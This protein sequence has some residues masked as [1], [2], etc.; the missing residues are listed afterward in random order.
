MTPRKRRWLIASIAIIAIAWIAKEVLWDSFTTLRDN[1]KTVFVKV[2]PHGISAVFDLKNGQTLYLP[3]DYNVV[4]KA[5]SQVYVGSHRNYW[6]RVFKNGQ[7]KDDIRGQWRF[8]IATG[9]YRLEVRERGTDQLISTVYI[10]AYFTK[11]EPDM[12]DIPS[13]QTAGGFIYPKQKTLSNID[14]VFNLYGGVCLKKSE[15]ILRRIPMNKTETMRTRQGKLFFWGFGFALPRLIS[16][17]Q[18]GSG[19]E[20]GRV[21]EFAFFQNRRNSGQ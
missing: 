19:E 3:F 17:P 7:L 18:E 10:K 11:D 21:S 5:R 2:D 16:R 14:R 20:C 12:T 13:L 6:I 4:T 1:P 9:D 15:P 8:P